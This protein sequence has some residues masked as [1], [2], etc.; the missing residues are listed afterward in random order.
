MIKKSILWLT[1]VVVVEGMSNANADT[2][3]ALR[4][5]M[6]SGRRVAQ[7]HDV[8]IST[9][10]VSNPRDLSEPYLTGIA[11]A[12]N[13][14]LFTLSF[15]PAAT[16]NSL[17]RVEQSTG[18]MQLIGSTGVRIVE[19]DID[20]HPLT[21]I[22]YGIQEEKTGASFDSNLFTIDLET[23]AA[24]V[25][26]AIVNYPAD[27]S[28]MAFDRNGTLFV[29]DT[30]HEALYTVDPTNAQIVTSVSL[31]QPLRG[32]AGMA[33]HPTTGA[34]Y[35]AD[36]HE[37]WSTM[38]NLYTLD[39]DTGLLTTIGPTIEYGL[40]GLAFVPEPYS[41]VSIDIKPG[42]DPNSI[43][44]GSNGN[45]P[46]AIFSTDTFDA[47]TVDPATVMLADAGVMER[48]KN[49]KLMASFEDIN[50]DGLLDLLVHIDTQSL[51]LN[52]D[53]VEAQLT[54]ETFDGLSIFGTD[55]INLVGKSG[56]PPTSPF[57]I[58][59]APLLDVSA[60]PE[61]SVIALLAAGILGLVL[62]RRR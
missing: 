23:G 30:T 44:L 1:V 46:V 58:E 55:A 38:R 61:P 42:S 53:D 49:G 39:S 56:G 25:I 52:D 14:D 48:G 60:V 6:D 20:F 31:S 37:V 62:L 18:D 27:L 10:A 40:A 15:F 54:G 21:G 57:T 59:D 50:L 22:L 24:S 34:L 4:D 51:V 43:N 9:G 32:M 12:P 19:G 29:L 7:L 13:N 47:M 36:G 11:F 35:V 2:L 28:A 41:D 3:L 16:P 8:D 5:F 26:G 45:I 33:F 17:F